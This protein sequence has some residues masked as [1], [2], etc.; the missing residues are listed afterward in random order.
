MSLRGRFLKGLKQVKFAKGMMLPDC[1]IELMT[2]HKNQ[3][4]SEIPKESAAAG[5]HYNMANVSTVLDG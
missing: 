5:F 1:V 4:P 2:N 3:A